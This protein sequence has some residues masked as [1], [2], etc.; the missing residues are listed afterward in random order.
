[1]TE[2]LKEL[3]E[4]VIYL[5]TAEVKINK[6]M[7]RFR[8]DMGDLS[9]LTDSIKRVGQ[10][11]PIIVNT[12]NEL[13]DGGRR[14]AAC[15]EAGVKVKA[16]RKEDIDHD[17]MREW[18]LEANLH[19]KDYTPAEEALAIK[20]LH[21][22]RQFRYGKPKEG[23]GG[24]H[25]VQDTANA[26][27]KSRATVSAALET[28]DLIQM[29]P[30]LKKA[31][32][33]SELK[34]AAQ[35]LRR[36][37]SAMNTAK[38]REAIFADHKD[39]FTLHQG[40]AVK[41]MRSLEDGT[42]DVICTDP[43]YGINADDL[44]QTLD[45]GSGSGFNT[46]GYTIEDDRDLAYMYYYE[47]AHQGY[48]IT[49]P[50]AHGFVFLAPEHF[51]RIKQ[52]FMEANWRTY[53]KPIIWIKKR[54]GQCNIPGSWPASCYEM[55]MYVRK[56][57]SRLVQEGKPDWEQYDPVPPSLKIHPYQK[58]VNL[59]KALL[60][61]VIIPGCI[62][63]DPFMGSGAT[64][65]A[66]LELGCQGIGVDNSPEAYASACKFIDDKLKEPQDEPEASDNAA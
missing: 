35:N 66:C 27:G 53:V 4:K 33:K 44:M 6:D 57:D 16:I 42:I 30:E 60:Q 54:T 28:A 23:V 50:E 9:G 34:K 32:K 40:D 41:H 2:T 55:V 5:D 36:V 1:M 22:R 10:I 59:L 29:F 61:R 58:P 12:E 37:A 65:A 3:K 14:L 24:G 11:L 17:L 45:G 52:I 39:K 64:I 21:E 62:V 26:I 13:C 15:M 43:I 63:Y 25:T 47:L 8:K 31:R 20:E 18:E 56:D 46:A 51:E 48:R 19:R 49:T 7:E 38:E